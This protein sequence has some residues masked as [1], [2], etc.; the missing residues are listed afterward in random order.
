MLWFGRTALYN[1]QEELH[2]LYLA[3]MWQG[4]VDASYKRTSAMVCAAALAI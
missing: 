1:L 3:V 4:E 2:I